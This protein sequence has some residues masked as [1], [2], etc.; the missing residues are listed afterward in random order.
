[1]K[2][3]FKNR[4]IVLVLEAAIVIPLCALGLIYNLWFI[5][6]AI[7]VW[8]AFTVYAKFIEPGGPW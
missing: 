8:F 7:C 6:G 1:M 4:F 3:F 2:R 5:I